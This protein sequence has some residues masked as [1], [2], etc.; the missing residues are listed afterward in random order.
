MARMRIL[1][2]V[3]LWFP[4]AGWRAFAACPAREALYGA[5]VV[6]TLPSNDP[7]STAKSH[8][9]L[10]G[11]YDG[12]GLLD[13][14][15]L[16]RHAPH[17]CILR[18]NG[19]GTF[20]AP[21]AYVL[22]ETESTVYEGMCQG[23][24]DGD[25][26]LDFAAVDFYGGRLAVVFNDGNAGLSPATVYSTGGGSYPHGIQ[27]EDMDGDGDLDLVVTY[28]LAAAVAIWK[29]DGKGVFTL[30]NMVPT[31]GVRPQNVGIGDF[32]GDGDLDYAAANSEWIGGGVPSVTIFRNGGDGR[33]AFVQRILT[34]PASG[35]CS[36]RVADLD[37]DGALDLVV[38]SWT[39]ASVCVLW[40]NG[41]GEFS[42]AQVLRAPP[43]STAVEPAIADLDRDGALDLVVALF[44]PIAEN[45]TRFALM[46][47]WGD[48]ARGFTAGPFLP[49]G[50]NPRYPVVEDFD[51]DGDPDIAS[52]QW[53]DSTVEVFEN[54][55]APGQRFVRGDSNADGRFNVADAVTVL[56][57]LF[58]ST[59]APSCLDGADINDDGAVNVADP[60]TLLG[61]LFAGRPPPPPPFAVCG[62]DPTEDALGCEAYPPCD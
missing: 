39:D 56:G 20:R 46:I 26:N 51:R 29:N 11:D 34:P 37:G 59:P 23:D 6:Y 2:V 28:D 38:G 50:V 55:C 13:C 12:D 47:F 9:L 21:E 35:P 18:G 8:V 53:Y 14:C 25:G 62:Y 19:D 54:L 30:F 36:C 3:L 32:D 57:Y 49:A 43:S 1:C 33:A 16:N 31:Q 10:S 27:A 45:P 41:K 40:G 15:V 48:G 24:L 42:E 17:I 5:P 58:A 4:C 61:Y 22:P 44:E 60:V 52:V 7:F